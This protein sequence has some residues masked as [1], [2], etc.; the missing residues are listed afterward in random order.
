VARGRKDPGE[1]VAQIALAEDVTTRAHGAAATTSAATATGI[2]FGDFDP[3]GANAEAVA[4][5]SQEIPTTAAAQG[6]T[7]VDA[8]VQAGLASSKGEARRAIEQG[9]IY[10][11]Q[12]R[13]QEIGDADWI[14][15]K[16][17]LLRKGK[18]DYALLKREG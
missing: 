14:A 9:G 2:L 16:N 5:Q 3:R 6:V 17:L 13:A 8:L 1:R 18:K 10:V 7:L 15:G 4:I 11:N 12:K